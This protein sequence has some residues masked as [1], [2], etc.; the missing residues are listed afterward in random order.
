MSRHA[1]A[2][3]AWSLAGLCVAMFL[4]SVT[5]VVLARSANVSGSLGAALTVGNLFI[6]VPFSAFPLGR[7][8]DRLKA[9]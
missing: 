2:W 8:P 4:G 5:L 9:S 3:L 6:F 7:R 1:A